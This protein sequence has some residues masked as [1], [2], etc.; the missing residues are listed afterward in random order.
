MAKKKTE[1]KGRPERKIDKKR[2]LEM[3][4]GGN[5]FKEMMKEF[6]LV[7]GQTLQMQ[8]Y[9]LSIEQGKIYAP[10]DMGKGSRDEVKHGK[11]GIRLSLALLEN[12][13]SNGDKYKVTFT[14]DEIKLTKVEV[15]QEAQAEV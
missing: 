7:S 11:A 10:S 12:H 15:K 9:K 2:L 6:N 1:K 13:S 4:E 14:E 3:A 5:S 8:L